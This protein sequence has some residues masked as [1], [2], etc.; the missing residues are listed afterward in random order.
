MAASRTL[1]VIE[2][3]RAG[4][5]AVDEACAQAR[6]TGCAVT[7]VGVAPQATAMHCVSSGE[8]LNDAILE[9]VIADLA[10]ARARL[11][12]SGIEVASRVLVDGCDPPLEEFAA[13]GGFD[14]ILLPSRRPR[15]VHAG[16]PSA[17]RLSG[18]TS[19]E[20]RL[21]ARP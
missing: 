7:L 20:V 4:D 1:V 3:G 2:A 16:H 6:R 18:R 13:T 12:T 5:A 10:R 19:A 9:A 11:A 14:L 8:G 15:W 17:R 21:V